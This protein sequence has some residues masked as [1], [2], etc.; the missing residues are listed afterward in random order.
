MTEIKGTIAEIRF[1]NEENGYTIATVETDL[2]PFTVVGVFPPVSEGSFVYCSGNFV[3]HPKFGRQ[4]KAD[5][6]RLVRPDSMYGM[7]QFLGSGMIKGIGS[8]RAEAIVSKFGGETF[9]VIENHP[10][11]LTKVSGISNRM[12]KE[13]ASSYNE[14]RIAADAMSFLMEYGVTSGLEIGRAHV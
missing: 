13:I 6:V 11:R 14:V 10:E 9:D 4:L 3:T 8:K 7:I 2:Q 1:R 5:T 12:A